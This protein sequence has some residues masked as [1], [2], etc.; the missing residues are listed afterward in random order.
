MKDGQYSL[1][2]LRRLYCKVMR[3]GVSN[4]CL[5]LVHGTGCAKH[6]GTVEKSAVQVLDV[7][8]VLVGLLVGDWGLMDDRSCG[9]VGRC[10]SSDR[11]RCMVLNGKRRGRRVF[12][13]SVE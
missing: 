9:Y 2:E 1:P 6:A 4:L 7:R 12:R 11:W 3:G 5:V 8:R 13:G 10:D